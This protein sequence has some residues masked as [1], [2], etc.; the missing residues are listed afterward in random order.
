MTDEQFDRMWELSE[1]QIKEALTL[2]EDAELQTLMS[3]YKQ[4]TDE[5]KRIIFSGNQY[6]SYGGEF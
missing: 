5:Y 3:E 1:K 2:D 6:L 4:T